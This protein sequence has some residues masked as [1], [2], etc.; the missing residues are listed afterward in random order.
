MSK[1]RSVLL[2]FALVV[3]LAACGSG[4]SD[5]SAP[6]AATSE[7]RATSTT[8]ATTTTTEVPK[9]DEATR[10]EAASH[11]LAEEDFPEGWT[12]V[13][14]ALPYDTKGIKGDDCINPKGGPVSE[15][16]LGSAAGG[17]TMRAPGADGFVS[18]WAVTFEDEA[19]A[20]RFTQQLTSPDHA[21]CTAKVLQTGGAKDREDFAVK[22]VPGDPGAR[23]I[24]Q[25]HR[26]A[27]DAYALTE[28]G[29]PVSNVYIDSFRIG[30]TVA[31]VTIELGPMTQEQA[32]AVTAAEAQVRTKVF[33]G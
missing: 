10:A 14:E 31:T 6:E 11:V 24:G 9:A 1:I 33:D 7:A 29:E 4:G 3:G 28:G 17:P 16:P 12:V 27:A 5:A 22:V 13:S 32:D 25:D 30:R 19:Q 15:V 8:K 20:A 21:T 18:S 23:G 2:P 26:I